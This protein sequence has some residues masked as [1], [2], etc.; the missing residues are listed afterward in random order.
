MTHAHEDHF[1]AIPTFGPITV[2]GLRDTFCS[3]GIAKEVGM[4]SFGSANTVN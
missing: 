2:S 4:A 1:D 3:I